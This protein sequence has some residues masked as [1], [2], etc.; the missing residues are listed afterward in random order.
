[1]YPQNPSSSC[2]NNIDD[3]KNTSMECNYMNATNKC[4]CIDPNNNS[5]FQVS[6][7]HQNMQ[8]V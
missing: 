4:K 7:N 2:N 6:D 3:H 8:Q 1:M 5:I